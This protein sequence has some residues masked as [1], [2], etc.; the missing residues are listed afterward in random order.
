MCRLWVDLGVWVVGVD[1]C[2]AGCVGCVDCGFKW[3]WAY[4]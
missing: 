4:V 2:V 1:S 3:T